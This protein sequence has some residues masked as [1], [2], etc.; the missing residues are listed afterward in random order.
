MPLH[1][2]ACGKVHLAAMINDQRRALYA[3]GKLERFTRNTLTDLEELE[4]ELQ[5]VSRDGVAYDHEEQ[6]LG[7]WAVAAPIYAGKTI[8]AAA[9]IISQTSRMEPEMVRNHGLKIISCSGEI[10]QILRRIY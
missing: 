8:I 6:Q 10:S 5:A 3:T 9:G 1:S 4:K 7:V 2:T